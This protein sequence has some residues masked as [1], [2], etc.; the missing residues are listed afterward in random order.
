MILLA[1]S[2]KYKP[3][4]DTYNRIH[5]QSI[6]NSVFINSK[7]NLDNERRFANFV[8]IKN[9]LLVMKPLFPLLSLAIMTALCGCSKLSPEAKEI[10]GTYYNPEVSQNE[11]I[12]ELKKNATCVIRAIKPG[13]LTYDVEGTWNVENDSLIMIINPSSIHF[14]GDSTLIG[15]IPER[16]ARK[17]T[18]H[19]EF[20]LQ[21]EQN[22]VSYIF[23]RR[24]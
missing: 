4:T 15:N 19:N 14:E 7:I 13:I 22:G 24:S 2:D 23:Q 21:L 3:A 12:M 20:S 5:G 16:I 1:K 11:P 8:S 10:V 9:P 18:E 17:V 6:V